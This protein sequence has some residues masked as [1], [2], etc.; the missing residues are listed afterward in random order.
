MVHVKRKLVP[1]GGKQD[2]D[3]QQWAEAQWVEA[4]IIIRRVRE[5]IQA[6]DLEKYSADTGTS[7]SSQATEDSNTN[8]ISPETVRSVHKGL[9]VITWDGT[10]DLANPMNWPVKKKAGVITIMAIVTLLT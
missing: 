9:G 6:I 1:V 2:E 4:D 8:S 10:D 7:T 3:I 5:S